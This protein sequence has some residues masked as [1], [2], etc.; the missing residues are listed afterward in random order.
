[1]GIDFMLDPLTDEAAG[2]AQA[3]ALSS[4]TVVT[5]NS[6]VLNNNVFNN[7]VRKTAC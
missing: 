1:M 4:P 6:N 2:L 5:P 7:N 3:S